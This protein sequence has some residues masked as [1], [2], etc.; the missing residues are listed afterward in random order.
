MDPFNWFDDHPAQGI[1]LLCSF[2]RS[3]FCSGIVL[4]RYDERKGSMLGKNL[5]YVWEFLVPERPN[6][7]DLLLPCL[8]CVLGQQEDC[9]FAVIRA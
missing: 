1:S 4:R 6:L 5:P 7:R 9:A 8:D 2:T 3:T